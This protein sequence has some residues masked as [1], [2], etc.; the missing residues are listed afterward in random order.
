MNVEKALEIVQDILYQGRLS[1]VQEIVFRQSWEGKSYQEMATESGYE[2]GYI[3]DVGSKLWQ[4][5][6]KTFGKKVTK[7][8]F[9]GVLKQQYIV[10]S[11]APRTGSVVVEEWLL[12]GTVPNLPS[13]EE[14][15]ALQCQDWGE[16]I[17]VSV[18]YGRA[19]ELATLN[20]WI[21]NDRCRLVA[22][23]GMGGI[24]KTALAVSIAE[25]VQG[26]FKYLIW[27]SLRNA[28]PVKEFLTEL[29]LFLSHQQEVN[30]P[31]TIESQISCLM[32]Y[33]RSSRCLLVLDNGESILRSGEYAGRYCAGYEGYGQLLRRVADE[34]HQ[35]CL[36]LTSR[37]KPIGLTAREGETLPVRS[38]QLTGLGQVEAQEI[39]KAKGLVPVEEESRKLIEYYTGNPL[40]LKI[41][42]T[43]I[44]SLF[45]GDV[46]RFSEQGT[47]IFSDV[48]EL[49][50]QQFNRL[51]PLEKE[52]MYWLATTEEQVTISELLEK[53]VP[54]VP[55][56]ELLKALE[57]LQQRSLIERSSASFTQQS[58]ILNYMSERGHLEL[59]ERNSKNY[60][61][62][63]DGNRQGS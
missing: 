30:L 48:W 28:P 56:R 6:S 38:L 3:T 45:N 4:L 16:A 21:V 62:I 61:Q 26:E 51:S 43:T 34:R 44:K 40:A 12:P 58:I 7:H 33:L 11:A 37:E 32:E 14:F 63:F 49:L 39:L 15:T 42:A 13:T 54:T 8:N 46:F 53:I 19:A 55:D 31:E 22:L 20:H 47:V 35:S 60:S 24:G 18:F 57:S 50:D 2:V 25:Q 52:V 10:K 9:Q 29:I 23:L 59:I 27:R 36:I 41:V 17:D 5:L 1:K